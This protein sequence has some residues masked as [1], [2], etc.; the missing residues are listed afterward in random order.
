MP[1][2]VESGYSDI[3]NAP[4]AAKLKVDGGKGPTIPVLHPADLPGWPRTNR[5]GGIYKSSAS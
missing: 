4:P 2:G 1:Y 5:Q 3:R